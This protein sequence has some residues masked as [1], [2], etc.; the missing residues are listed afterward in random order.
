VAEVG[1]VQDKNIILSNLAS[2]KVELERV[3]SNARAIGQEISKLEDDLF[4]LGKS[5]N[6]PKA[7]LNPI[8]FSEKKCEECG[9]YSGCSFNGKEDYGRFKL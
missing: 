8:A 6:N 3:L 4:N 9:F 2:R 7:C 5:L 1:R